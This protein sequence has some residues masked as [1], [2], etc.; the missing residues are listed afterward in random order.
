MESQLALALPELDGL[1]EP[2]AYTG[3]AG[4]FVDRVV[5]AAKTL[6]S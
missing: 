5:R 4:A 6:A 1:L 3:L 2:T